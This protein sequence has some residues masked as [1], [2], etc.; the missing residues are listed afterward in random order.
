MNL[1]LKAACALSFAAIASSAM[2]ADKLVVAEPNHSFGYL[3]L[4][5]AINE[6]YFAKHG[7]DVS[8]RTMGSGAGST[9]AVLSGQAFGFIGGP[10][11]DAFVK[12]KG[13]EMRAVVNVVDRGN[14]YLV[15]KK[16]QE[17]KPGQNLA[18]YFKGKTFAI[19]AYGSTPNSIARYI[20]V[21]SGLKLDQ[22]TLKEMSYE[23]IVA[24]L[25]VGQAQIG[26]IQ[27]PLLQKGKTEGIWGEPF[28]NVPKELGHYAYSV[29]NIREATIKEHP[30][31][32]KNFVLALVEGL[33]DIYAHPDK[34]LQIA[35]KEF[36]TMS[37]DDLKVTF[38]R[39]LKDKIWS[40][41][42]L[43]SQDGWKTAQSVTM[44][45]GVLK[46]EV[47]FDSIIDMQFVPAAKK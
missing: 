21:K 16:G 35:R 43:I 11:H 7:L 24:T 13:G 6:G 27:E 1:F 23:G 4:Y 26:I 9:N 3:P 44:Q 39:G 38:D 31:Q 5:I 17:P 10:E 37:Q 32:V 20:I 34:A 22:V 47:P 15:A 33:K 18:D 36:P 29:I 28:Y 12:L 25:K 2:A 45:A 42:G 14:V 30:D 41:D 46:K 19:S 40:E 8:M